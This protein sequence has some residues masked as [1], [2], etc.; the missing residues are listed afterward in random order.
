LKTIVIRVSK[1]IMKILI[2]TLALS[3]SAEAHYGF[4]SDEVIARIPKNHIHNWDLLVTPEGK[5]VLID[6]NPLD[7]TP[8][9]T[10]FFNAQKDVRFWLYTQQNKVIPFEI[11]FD[12]LDSVKNS[13]FNPAWPTRYI[14][15]GWQN[16]GKSE[17]NIIL[18]DAYLKVGYYNV[19]IVDWGKGASDPIYNMS[20]SYIKSV[21]DVCARLIDWLAAE[22]RADIMNIH[23]IGH[24]LGGHTAGLIGKAVKG[25]KIP[26]IVALDPAGVNFWDNQP[27]DRVNKGDA[28][29][30][31]IIHTNAGKLGYENPLGDVDIYANDGS[32][33]PGCGIDLV[34]MCAHGMSFKYFAETVVS[35][36]RCMA[37]R[38]TT[39]KDILR[40]K[41]TASGSPVHVGGE[42]V[43]MKIDGHYQ[44]ITRKD[45]PYCL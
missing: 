10:P 2:L 28:S 31:E 29:Y 8:R 12:E 36:A 7:S 19:I 39:Y 33:Q 14:I 42:P 21:A 1:F 43:D 34:G 16:D 6:K 23:L 3:L 26:R 27:N 13:H 38:C 9:A 32:N 30:V 18:R 35:K 5:T 24:S 37:Q 20:R 44:L 4:S 11:K 15:H 22:L 25:G 45:S 41:C 40:G 17:M